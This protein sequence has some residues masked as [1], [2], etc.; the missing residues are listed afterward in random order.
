[1][2]KE[3]GQGPEVGGRRSY[4]G[5]GNS[6]ETMAES[7][8]AAVESAKSTATD[9]I[10]QQK[11][12]AS[13][14]IE[15]FAKAVR[16][17]S[18][19]LSSQDQTAAARLVQEAAGGLENLSHT[20]ANQSLA[21]MVATARDFGRRNPM[22]LAGGAAL[23]GMALGRVARTAS[24]G[25][26]ESAHSLPSSG[27]R[28]VPSPQ[29]SGTPSGPEPAGEFPATRAAA[30]SQSKPSQSR[31]GSPSQSPGGSRSSG[32]SNE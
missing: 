6:R 16:K 29:A 22:A 17:A 26:H 13:Q 23:L 11:R 27:P 31:P 15:A 20:L 3:T 25:S 30:P 1:M 8:S 19:E 18:D 14:S 4:P 10:E 28:A 9:Q 32:G 7:A 12:A 21:D 5:D 24:N 2:V